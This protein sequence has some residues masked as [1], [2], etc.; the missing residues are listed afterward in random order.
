MEYN[1]TS[2]N[3]GEDGPVLQFE[4]SIETNVTNCNP[5]YI[6]SI[7]EYFTAFNELG[8]ALFTLGGI[9]LLI[10]L[11]LYLD[12]VKHIIEKA[13]T[14]TKTHSV[15][16]M[17]V[18]PVVAIAT[19]C[20]T[21]V[22]RA[23]LLAE[24]VTQGMFMACLYQ[25]F[26]LVVAYCGG[27]AEM[28]KKIHPG[29]LNMQVTPCC[30]WPCCSILPHVEL[31]KKHVR[32]LRMLVLQLPVVQGLI[33]MI[34]LVMWAEEQSLYQVNYNYFQ[35][36]VVMSILFGIWGMVMTMKVTLTCLKDYHIQGK[37]FVLQLVLLF[38]KFQGFIAK[39]VATSDLFPCRYPITSS[40]YANLIYNSLIIWEIV[41]LCT[42]ARLLYKKSIPIE[43]YPIDDNS[44][45]S[46]QIKSKDDKVP[47]EV[48]SDRNV[49]VV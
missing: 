1:V 42:I 10:V 3:H 49:P 34:L 7:D 44:N 30:C 47:K 13:P 5:L 4:T 24:A 40:V 26:C 14:G 29:T 41:L 21:I 39:I 17:S 32:A 37:F 18:Y 23:Q 20:A 6:P 28:I 15:F 22:P 8:L 2:P 31:K 25:L 45:F 48:I 11:S 27:E 38:A 35:P 33:Y 19:Y 36:L 16:I 9:A 46:N 43:S 12:T